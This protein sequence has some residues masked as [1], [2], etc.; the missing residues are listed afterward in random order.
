MFFVLHS[1]LE[2]LARPSWSALISDCALR[3]SPAF[4]DPSASRVRCTEISAL[5]EYDE[6]DEDQ[7]N[8]AKANS[9]DAKSKKYD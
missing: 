9:G 6:E 1:V 3:S 5:M 7:G 8:E 2:T 4:W